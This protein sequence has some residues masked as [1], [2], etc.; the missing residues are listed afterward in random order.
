M[1]LGQA[2]VIPSLSSSLIEFVAEFDPFDLGLY[3]RP[4]TLRTGM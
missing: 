1:M 4:S 2:R 3:H